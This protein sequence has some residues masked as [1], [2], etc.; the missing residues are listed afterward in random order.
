MSQKSGKSRDKLRFGEAIE[1]LEAILRRV[2][3]EE[4]DIDE[5]ADTSRAVPHQDPQ[6]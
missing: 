1:E 6:G 2:E 3:A 5:L 4:V